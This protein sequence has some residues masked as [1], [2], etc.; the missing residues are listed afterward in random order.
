MP[1]S[2]IEFQFLKHSCWFCI[3]TPTT[4]IGQPHFLTITSFL[5][6]LKV[7]S[8]VAIT[9]ASWRNSVRGLMRFMSDLAWHVCRTA[10]RLD[11]G[12]TACHYE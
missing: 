8:N 11:N 7:F 12:I 5:S 2:D 6:D 3:T 1:D 10:G 4:H 9:S